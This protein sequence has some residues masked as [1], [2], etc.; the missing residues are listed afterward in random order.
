MGCTVPLLQLRVRPTGCH[1]D[2]ATLALLETGLV[3]CEWTVGS[4]ATA[5]ICYDT[6]SC[7]PGCAIQ[8]MVCS[9]LFRAVLDTSVSAF[10]SFRAHWPW[11][12]LNV[13]NGGAT[14][15]LDY[16]PALTD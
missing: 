15:L 13:Q 11:C 7:M 4:W 3:S 14:C 1:L 16:L 6:C 12:V 8:M 2:M 5:Q 9:L 10:V